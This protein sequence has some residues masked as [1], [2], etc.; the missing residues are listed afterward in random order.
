[1]N[2][3]REQASNPARRQ[4]FQKAVAGAS[5]LG[6][7]GMAGWVASGR[8]SAPNPATNRALGSEFTYDLAGLGRIDSRL[9]CFKEM[10]P[11]ATGF[12][13][14]RGVAVDGEGRICAAGDQSIRVFSSEG[15]RVAEIALEERPCCLATSKS[16]LLYAG[17]LQHVEVFHPDGTRAARWDALGERSVITSITAGVD[18]VF[19]ADAGNRVV[20]RFDLS[21]KPLNQIGKKD[22][23]RNIP[24]FAVPSPY[25]EVD[26]DAGGLV[27][28]VNPANHRL[29]AYTP[30]GEWRAS[31][32]EFSN[33][34]EG[35]CGCCNPI[36]FARLPDGRFVTSEKGLPRV[37]FYSAKG[38]FEGV[39]AGPEQFS[40]QLANP[41]AI[42]PCMALAADARGRVLLA[43]A[44]SRQIRIFAPKTV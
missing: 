21:G 6:L 37:K 13:E 35:F 44:H 34:I 24:G 11:L 12:Q 23:E 19:V 14:L 20:V 42:K 43:D 7:G 17:M 18:N 5:L 10:A 27:W 41:R 29:E 4:F 16:G 38:E 3:E 2:A 39:V 15:V 30:E 36:H 33:A 25:F 1:M 22:P 31:W 8:K 9:I 28:A 32:G 40:Q 26:V